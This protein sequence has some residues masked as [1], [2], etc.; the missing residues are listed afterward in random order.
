MTTTQIQRDLAAAFN[1]AKYGYYIDENGD[2][3]LAAWNLGERIN[4]IAQWL[5]VDFNNDGTIHQVP[6]TL[7][8]SFNSQGKVEDIPEG[9]PIGQAAIT[10][11]PE[12]AEKH[13]AS[14]YRKRG[15]KFDPEQVSASTGTITNP[16]TMLR[17]GDFNGIHNILQYLEALL[18]DFNTI[19]N[20]AD[21]AAW[22]LPNANPVFT[23]DEDG[24]EI[25]VFAK[26][27]GI[28]SAI[29]EM[30]YVQSTFSRQITEIEQSV[31]Q[32]KAELKELFLQVGGAVTYKQIPYE[33]NGQ[34][35]YGLPYVGKPSDTPS[36]QDLLFWLLANV[37]T[38]VG[39]QTQDV[40]TAFDTEQARSNEDTRERFFPLKN[41]NDNQE[42]FIEFS[43]GTV[44]VIEG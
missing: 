33:I 28:M 42:S 18:D 8:R 4:A 40:A 38:I 30:M 9:Y 34:K 6:Q 35:G 25:E 20:S 27:Q 11:N 36:I 26:G 23:T 3:Q 19:L 2:Q 39:S 1:P 32:I 21:A 43:D 44:V 17:R 29:A 12:T 5:G 10:E 24:N 15:N 22:I 31:L 7:K 13:L 41:P 16:E 37:G 14:I